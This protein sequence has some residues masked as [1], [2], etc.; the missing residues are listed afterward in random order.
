MEAVPQ[1]VLNEILQLLPRKDLFACTLVDKRLNQ[2]AEKILYTDRWQETFLCTL[3][4]LSSRNPKVLFYEEC[5]R[6]AKVLEHFP[7]CDSGNVCYSWL[8]WKNP[9]PQRP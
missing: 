4:N 9:P 5:A 7:E 2:L 3:P 6:A 8:T 1:D